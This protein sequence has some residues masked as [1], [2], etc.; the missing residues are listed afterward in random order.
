[1]GLAKLKCQKVHRSHQES[2]TILN[3]CS[4]G[5]CKPLVNFQ[6]VTVAEKG[7]QILTDFA[8]FSHCLIEGQNF[9]STI[10]TNVT[11]H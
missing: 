9:E 2:A 1:M 4:L 11:P 10:V 7:K 6:W 3:K 8:H 5:G